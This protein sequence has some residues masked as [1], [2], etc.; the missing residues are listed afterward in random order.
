MCVCV[1]VYLMLVGAAG[2]LSNCNNQV[3]FL[4]G[5]I[6]RVRRVLFRDFAVFGVALRLPRVGKT[7]DVPFAIFRQATVVASCVVAS[8]RFFF[9][10]LGRSCRGLWGSLDDVGIY[11]ITRCCVGSFA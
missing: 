1:C 10:A 11:A 7:F 2:I 9:F 5:V 8:R 3:M 4:R 6:R